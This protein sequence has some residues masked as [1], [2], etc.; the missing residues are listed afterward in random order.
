MKTRSQKN[1]K[2]QSLHLDQHLW[3]TKTTTQITTPLGSPDM[4]TG[5]ITILQTT[6]SPTT[7]A[8]LEQNRSKKNS[9]IQAELEK[10]RDYERKS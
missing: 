4:V 3:K 1:L 2:T 6:K 9:R 7:G 5:V 8:P 10:R